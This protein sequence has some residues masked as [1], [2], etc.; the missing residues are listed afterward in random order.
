VALT[1][2]QLDAGVLSTVRCYDTYEESLR[3]VGID[4]AASSTVRTT[5]ADVVG[6]GLVSLADHYEEPWGGGVP[7]TIWGNQ[8][9]D[10]GGVSFVAGDP[11]NDRIRSTAPRACSRVKH[12][13]DAGFS[14]SAETIVKNNGGALSILPGAVSSMRYYS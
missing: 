6:N 3:A 9:C 5:S 12:F 14:G 2:E 13:A 4:P 7:L 1:A 11:W 8:V 10:G